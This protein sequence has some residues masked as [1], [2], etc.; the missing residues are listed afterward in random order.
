MRARRHSLRMLSSC[1][2]NWAA[3]SAGFEADAGAAEREL[4]AVDQL[5]FPHPDAVHLR[6][7]GRLEVDH[8]VARALRADLGVV[9]TDVGIGENDVRLGHP[10]HSEAVF[11]EH[12]PLTRRK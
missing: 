4:V 9:T 10:S 1:S 6:A 12:D 3:L 7:V 2:D 5:L 11:P 8:R